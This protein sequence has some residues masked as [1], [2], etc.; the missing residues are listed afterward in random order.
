MKRE[1]V[2]FTKHVATC[3]VATALG[4]SPALAQNSPTPGSNPPP[5]GT[6]VPATAS[7]AAQNVSATDF[8]NQAANSDM[9]EIQSSQLAVKAQDGKVHDFA[10]R[11]INDHTQAS[12]KLRAA[13]K[14]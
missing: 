9:F 2:M 12:E 7:P 4:A 13:A 6:Q 3:L 8:V 14:G 1:G 10:Q 5:A 11:M